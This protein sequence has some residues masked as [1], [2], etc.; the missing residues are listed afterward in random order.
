[1]EFQ[2]AQE[3][4]VVED[5]ETIVKSAIGV[6]LKDATYTADKANDWSNNII[7]SCLKGLQSLH[8]P[9]KYC[10][11]VTIIQKNGAGIIS[12]VS[13]FWDP[14]KDGL[15]RVSWENATMHCNVAISG[16]SHNI[17]SFEN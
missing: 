15:C 8:R 2:S 6:V 12:S 14:A 4:F 17:D 7:A 5:V 16:T 1:M 13:T 9:F 3:D 10:V 11:I